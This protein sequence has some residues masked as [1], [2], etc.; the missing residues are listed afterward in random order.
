MTREPNAKASAVRV[1]FPA[2]P[3]LFTEEQNWVETCDKSNV[4][5]MPTVTDG[6]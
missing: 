5:Y 6:E 2:T 4:D 3:V 1:T